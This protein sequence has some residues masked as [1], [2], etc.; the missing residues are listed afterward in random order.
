M[1][2]DNAIGNNQQPTINNQRGFTLLELLLSVAIFAILATAASGVMVSAVR[3]YQ[4]IGAGQNFIDNTQFA[5]EFMSRQLR[6]ARKGT[7]SCIT[8][9][10]QNFDIFTT[11][12]P[13]DSIRFLDYQ[14]RCI[15]YQ[16]ASSEIR[17]SI[18]GAA[19]V[20]LTYSGMVQISDLDFTVLGASQTDT[21][22]PRVT[23]RVLAQGVMQGA[24][25][26]LVVPVQTTVSTRFVDTP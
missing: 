23:I 24:A 6:L 12:N 25:L 1:I 15:V 19:A 10:Q 5:L 3:S 18:N 7:P 14:G 9:A 2:G 20:S 11:V 21:L 17:Q 8:G 4:Q 16:L 26:G 13:N 22:E